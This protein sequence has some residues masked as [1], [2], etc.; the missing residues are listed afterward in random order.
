M[1]ILH[2]L[3]LDSQDPFSINVST[4]E[5]IKRNMTQGEGKSNEFL[6]PI[7]CLPLFCVFDLKCV[8]EVGA[9]ERARR[10][11]WGRHGVSKTGRKRWRMKLW[12]VRVA[13]QLLRRRNEMSSSTCLIIVRPPSAWRNLAN[14]QEYTLAVC[15][16][17]GP[18]EHICTSFC[19]L[20]NSE[21][22]FIIPLP[23][24]EITMQIPFI[25]CD[26]DN[27]SQAPQ[28]HYYIQSPWSRLQGVIRYS[29]G[30]LV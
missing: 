6:A 30:M 9:T 20:T 24:I 8:K 27:F 25:K 3:Y 23:L 14:P 4:Q 18:C 21:V 28:G 17:Y 10:E 13:S 11:R 15:H 22:S 7:C 26:M 12:E 19:R 16:T 2:C 29:N 1:F 5:G